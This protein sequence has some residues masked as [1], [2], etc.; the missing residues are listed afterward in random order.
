M[1]FLV[2]VLV[3]GILFSCP[4][5]A[6]D[7]IYPNTVKSA[8]NQTLA[9]G[10]GK[11]LAYSGQIAHAEAGANTAESVKSV[12]ERLFG[13]TDAQVSFGTAVPGDTDKVSGTPKLFYQTTAQRHA[14]LWHHSGVLSE[15]WLE[16]AE[17]PDIF[18]DW[19]SPTTEDAWEAYG[20]HG[21]NVYWLTANQ[22]GGPRTGTV[23]I[24]NAIGATDTSGVL[25]PNGALL[26]A[27]QLPRG[28]LLRYTATFTPE[29]S[30]TPV[31][32]S[33][34]ITVWRAVAQWPDISTVTAEAIATKLATLT[35][36]NR[37]SYKALKETPSQAIVQQFSID[38]STLWHSTYVGGTD[39]F[40]RFNVSGG[41]W[42]DVFPIGDHQINLP[43][44]STLSGIDAG[45][46][47][48]ATVN[49]GRVTIAVLPTL[50]VAWQYL[51]DIPS[52]AERW[53]TADEVSGIDT[54][55]QTY[56]EKYGL[57]GLHAPIWTQI[58]RQFLRRNSAY[59]LDLNDYVDDALSFNATGLPAGISLNSGILSG[60]PTTE[61]V[62][63][64][65]I[66]ATNSDGT[67]SFVL[68]MRVL[69]DV[70]F[71]TSF[72]HLTGLTTKGTE[73]AVLRGTTQT[74]VY[75][76][77]KQGVQNTGGTVTFSDGTSPFL[78]RDATALAWDGTYWA[79]QADWEIGESGAIALWTATGSP[80]NTGSNT[81]QSAIGGVGL[82]Y[83]GNKYWN[84]KIAG[85]IPSRTIV[86]NRFNSSTLASESGQ[87]SID[88]TINPVGLG[89]LANQ[90]YVADSDGDKVWVYST[91]GAR[92]RYREFDLHSGNGDP[93]GITYLDNY[94]YVTEKETG[95]VN[96]KIYVYPSKELYDPAV[97]E[98]TKLELISR[99]TY[100]TGNAVRVRATF[101]GAVDISGA[102]TLRLN[103]GNVERQA[104]SVSSAT[105]TVAAPQN[106]VTVANFLYTIVE[107]DTDSDG[108]TSYAY[109]F[110]TTGS[111]QPAGDTLTAHSLNA[112]TSA[113][114]LVEPG[115]LN[116][117][118][119][120]PSGKVNTFTQPNWAEADPG[121][122]GYI[123][124]KPTQL[125]AYPNT[126]SLAQ[127]DWREN[128][129]LGIQFN[130]SGTHWNQLSV[131]QI[132]PLQNW[133]SSK[134]INSGQ[135]ILLRV[136]VSV[137][138]AG[139][140]D[141]YLDGVAYQQNLTTL[142][143]DGTNW[144]IF[145]GALPYN[146]YLYYAW[147]G[148]LT[149]RTTVSAVERKLPY[150]VLVDVPDSAVYQEGKSH[151]DTETVYAAAHAVHITPDATLLSQARDYDIPIQFSMTVRWR[152][153]TIQG[154]SN[155][156]SMSITMQSH[157]GATII[158]TSASDLPRTTWTTTKLSGVL[159]NSLPSYQILVSRTDSHQAAVAEIDSVFYRLSLDDEVGE[160]FNLAAT[161]PL[162]VSGTTTKTI[163]MPDGSVP[164][165]KLQ[166][167]TDEQKK[168][169]RDA[170]GASATAD[171]QL[172]STFRITSF[173]SGL[174]SHYEI[175][176]N[177]PSALQT[178][179][180]G[181]PYEFIVN[182][183]VQGRDNQ[184]TV[185]VDVGVF[186]EANG[187]GDEWAGESVTSALGVRQNVTLTGM[188][189]PTETSF[190]VRWNRP[191]GALQ[192]DGAG[193]GQINIGT[194]AE[195]VYV[196]AEDFSGNLST[197]D[198]TVQEV[199]Q[200]VD[201]L[202]TALSWTPASQ[203][204]SVTAGS[205]ITTVYAHAYRI[206]KMVIV[207]A[208]LTVALSGSASLFS[209]NINLPTGSAP[210]TV[211]QELF[212]VTIH[213]D[214]IDVSTTSGNELN[215][216]AN[217][218][219][220]GTHHTFNINGIYTLD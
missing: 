181:R 23:Y 138:T 140:D 106:N 133:T 154:D 18:I 193:S 2:W 113:Y 209:V 84:V 151:I 11:I 43:A 73:L 46:G 190:I 176:I 100:T 127:W 19:K 167:G 70:F 119:A 78:S 210:V 152:T 129:G 130:V 134:T 147:K 206:G 173:S 83:G 54:H 20:V 196:N 145:H 159:S 155:L 103:I 165:E 7:A 185:E 139:A 28:T 85:L 69:R 52:Y 32:S 148:A 150:S 1:R 74:N 99:G 189:P 49:S 75:L 197:S 38:G 80:T 172:A 97:P 15:D 66:S 214:V 104:I 205:S 170:I 164:P 41:P 34:T 115:G 128:D 208:R 67:S 86:I 191:A 9:T 47:I 132:A 178:A 25:I 42:S 215:V 13:I 88:S 5:L 109:P 37:L 160:Q 71:Q 124:N 162:T 202:G 40:Y 77:S 64:A 22:T 111:F 141:V 21:A 14:I 157:T 39:K 136:P 184:Q 27:V 29:G 105:G 146:G 12:L 81:D 126:V 63:F 91:A 107:A 183:W 143:T 4:V 33:D 89:Y 125:V 8:V 203:S 90:L 44:G 192:F 123:R 156:V 93:T 16:Y 30:S 94:W 199:A 153:K 212:G 188:L 50:A 122:D 10:P 79:L 200:K 112:S 61:Q 3:F 182:G 218:V 131:F 175:E 62:V 35:G 101:S 68:P 168:A 220:L 31:T 174:Q 72:Q 108:I 135:T 116:K 102:V 45:R 211:S 55:I 163:A 95:A 36:T 207:N 76:Y 48:S 177:I 194:S 149:A 142:R 26:S 59:E 195:H 121:S 96:D 117:L 56:L 137:F 216:F 204:S 219:M 120:S 51:R 158:S 198:D 17:P 171:V 60:T 114:R 217:H 213:S 92:D 180:G 186:S 166:T 98:L 87:I 57:T 53:P 58:P 169:F 179:A 118:L 65:T 187:G 24:T 144:N 201:D 6:Q 82:V 161:A 110:S